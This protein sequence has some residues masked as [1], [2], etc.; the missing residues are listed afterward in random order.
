MDII[1]YEHF[2]PGQ[3][4]LNTPNQN[5]YSPTTTNNSPYIVIGAVVGVIILL[6][7]IS[8]SVNTPSYYRERYFDRGE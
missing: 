4:P 8:S 1:N 7:I 3:P 5:L 2:T 6:Y